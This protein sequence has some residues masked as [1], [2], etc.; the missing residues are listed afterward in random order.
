MDK[1]LVRFFP[2]IDTWPTDPFCYGHHHQPATPPPSPSFADDTPLSE[3]VVFNVAT[4]TRRLEQELRAAKR[5]HLSCGEVLLP[6]GL[7]QKV[8]FIIEADLDRICMGR[9]C[10]MT[11][12]HV[13][14]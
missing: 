13:I 12:L 1:V 10:Q 6:C 3:D 5:S 2:F 9:K 14:W 11:C 8:S 4:L 7:L